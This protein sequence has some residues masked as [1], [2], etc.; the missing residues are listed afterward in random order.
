MANDQTTIS[1]W[2][3]SYTN[4]LYRWAYHKTS[5]S[6]AAKDLVQETFLAAV[7]Q[8]KNFQGTSSPKTWLFSI[9]NH[10]IMDYYRRKVKEPK[11]LDSSA[12][13]DFFDADE[14]W[15]MEKRPHPWNNEEAHLLDNEEFQVILKKCMDALPERWHTGVKLKYLMEKS[16]EE[17]CQELGIAPTNLWQI[18][19]RA[20]LQLRD[21]VEKKWL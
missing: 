15:R 13:A 18:I 11:S 2:V 14:N 8:V 5:N 10:K 7:E 19:H 21:C 20:K 16:G 1:Q 6:E 3:A 17:I 12:T 4:D 9:L